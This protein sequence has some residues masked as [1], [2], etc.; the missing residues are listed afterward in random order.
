MDPLEIC[1]VEIRVRSLEVAATFYGECFGWSMQVMPEAG[2]AICDT[3]GP[4]IM[5][6]MQTANDSVPT[7]VVAYLLVKDAGAA[8]DRAQELGG[9]VLLPR[10][11][12]GESG[13]W[14]HTIDPWGNELAFWEPRGVF[15]PRFV[16]DGR[17]A[18]TWLELRAP[19][20]AAAV[21]YY[22]KLAGWSFQVRPSID[23]FA[24]FKGGG[25]GGIGLVGGEKGQRL[26]GPTYY[27]TAPDFE[28]VLK[29]VT[30][31]GGRL[32]VPS[33]RAPDGERFA[34]AE[35]PDGNPVGLFETDAWEGKA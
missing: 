2:Y 33:A 17:H 26:A 21:R 29:R 31:H 3:G 25:R 1:Q 23:D 5:G 11:Q 8:A 24:F 19:E 35:D 15:A 9:R 16:G 22:K 10:T 32:R 6:I 20:L 13:W 34:V 4:P 7:G 14:S 28:A 27:V 30:A 12:S 18:M